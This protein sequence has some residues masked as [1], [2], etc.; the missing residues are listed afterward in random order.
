MN[1]KQSISSMRQ[2]VPIT[3]LAL[4]LGCVAFISCAK[5]EQKAVS[6][7]ATTQT[8]HAR[9][10]GQDGAEMVLIPA[11]EFQMGSNDSDAYDD[12]K[13]VHTV[14]VDAFYMDKYEV[15]VGQYKQFV[16]ATGHRALPPWVSEDSPTDQHPVVGVSWHD[17]MAYAKW[18]GK[19]LPTEAEWEKAARGGLSGMKY[20]WGNTIS[21]ANANY[22]GN[23]GKTTVVGRYAANGYGLHDMAGN[24]WEWCLDAYDLA[25][26]SSS[27]RKNPLSDVGTLSNLH[28]ILDNYTDVNN[29][30]VLRGGSWYYYAQVV[31][32]ADRYR[33]TPTGTDS[34]YGFRC[35][36]AVSP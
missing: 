16:R 2:I 4:L 10:T 28:L 24:V 26:Y 33:Y 19:R 25:F 27:V 5:T 34:S 11:G 31:R 13:P 12:E 30:R 15:T 6:P 18:A 17:A 7:A 1:T 32:C 8:I 29:S 20:P 35:A 22:G 9:I 21:S 3:W 36:R 23:V 14:Y